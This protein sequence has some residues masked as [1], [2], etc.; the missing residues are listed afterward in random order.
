MGSIYRYK[1]TA[2]KYQAEVSGCKDRGFEIFTETK[3]CPDC[4]K[5]MDVGT[6]L[7]KGMKSAKKNKRNLPKSKPCCPKCGSLKIQSW[8]VHS[9]PK[10]G[11]KMEKD[12]GRPICFWD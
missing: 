3:V 12:P 2:C 6:Y 5:V 7:V 11:G 1:C 8:K 4:R 10:C 9:C